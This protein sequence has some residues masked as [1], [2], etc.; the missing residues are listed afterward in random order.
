MR[1]GRIGKLIPEVGWVMEKG[2]EFFVKSRITNQIYQIQVTGIGSKIKANYC[3]KGAD[4]YYG[5]SVF[6][7]T[8]YKYYE[9]IP[10]EVKDSYEIF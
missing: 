10:E 1:K 7:T 2:K 6:A 4:H 3:V 9:F 5:S 8:R